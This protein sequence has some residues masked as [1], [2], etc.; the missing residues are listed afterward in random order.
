MGL[1][2]DFEDEVSVLNW[3]IPAHLESIS[4]LSNRDNCSRREF[5]YF[6]SKKTL[7]HG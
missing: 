3:K 5:E 6:G 2:E 1:I 7:G 4:G